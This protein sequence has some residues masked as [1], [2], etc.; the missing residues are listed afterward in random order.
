MTRTTSSLRGCRAPLVPASLAQALQG[1]GFGRG[2][3]YIL[4]HEAFCFV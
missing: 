1:T 4:P 2:R 3:R